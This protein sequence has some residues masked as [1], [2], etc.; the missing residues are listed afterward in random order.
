MLTQRVQTHRRRPTRSWYKAKIILRSLLSRKHTRDVCRHKTN[1]SHEQSKYLGKGGELQRG[2][3]SS[4]PARFQDEQNTMAIVLRSLLSTKHT[5]DVCPHK[6]K[7]SYEQSK[8]LGRGGGLQREESSSAPAR[9]QDEQNTM[10]ALPT[11]HKLSA[12]AKYRDTPRGSPSPPSPLIFEIT[13]RTLDAI[14]RR[15]RGNP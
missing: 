15:L 5:R 12:T 14:E 3:S 10:A 7:V 11:T 2:E 6:T 9:L 4:A 8:Y 1:V 13:P